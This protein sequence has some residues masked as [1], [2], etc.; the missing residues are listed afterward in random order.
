MQVGYD[1]FMGIFPLKRI[2]YTKPSYSSALKECCLSDFLA[3]LICVHWSS[4]QFNQPWHLHHSQF[5]YWREEASFGPIVLGRPICTLGP[6]SRANENL[7]WAFCCELLCGWNLLVV[8]SVWML[9]SF[10]SHPNYS[11]SDGWREASFG[12]MLLGLVRRACAIGLGRL[13]R[14]RRR[15]LLQALRWLSLSWH[16]RASSYLPRGTLKYSE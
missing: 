5:A 2:L 16:G 4:C 9:P 1:I 12:A 6:N 10:W 13:H 15:L 7:L 8:L 3:E 11:H 14:Q